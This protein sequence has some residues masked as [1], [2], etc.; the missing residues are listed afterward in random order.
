MTERLIQLQ[1]FYELAMS[2]GNHPEIDKMLEES[3]SAYLRKLNC[4]AGA[5]FRMDDKQESVCRFS[6]LYTIPRGIKR[7]PVFQQALKRIPDGLPKGQLPQFLKYLP[8]HGKSAE[9][10]FYHIMNL[11]DFGLLLLVKN[12]TDL[13][14]PVLRSLADLNEKLAR[15]C[16]ACLRNQRLSQ[17]TE[18][19]KSEIHRRTH[20]ETSLKECE[21]RCRELSQQLE[22]TGNK[23]NEGIGN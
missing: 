23:T 5:V 9:N 20:I 6:T 15:S 8:I 7:N 2:I 12:N 1:V 22:L 21:E 19:L 3:L 14:Q 17:Y 18:Y 4:S 10:N 13:K 16:N 11:P